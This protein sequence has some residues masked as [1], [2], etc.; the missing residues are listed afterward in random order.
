MNLPEL[1]RS[2]LTAASSA[3]D[4]LKVEVGHL[5]AIGRDVHGTVYATVPESVRPIVE[6]VGESIV[7]ENGNDR[8]AT[9]KLTF[10]EPIAVSMEDLF[11]VDGV[12][13]NVAKR[14]GLRDPDTGM[15]YYSEVWLGTGRGRGR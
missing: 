4:S 6:E 10:L 3:V 15:T 8:M 12:E 14:G 9:S 2:A 13:H 5:R 7:D 11:I 1:L